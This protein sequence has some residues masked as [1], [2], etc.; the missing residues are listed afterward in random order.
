MTGIGI[1]KSSKQKYMFGNQLKKKKYFFDKFGG[2]K[3]EYSRIKFWSNGVFPF[4]L[5]MGIKMKM[6]MGM[7]FSF[8]F[9]IN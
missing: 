2:M 1:R 6:K 8:L 3:F 7:G 9:R 4:P 5:A